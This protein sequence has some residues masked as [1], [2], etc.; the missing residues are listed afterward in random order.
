M[1]AVCLLRQQITHTIFQDQSSE[2]SQ[3]G[4]LNLNSS[5][6]VHFSEAKLFHFLNGICIVEL[7]E[8]RLYPIGQSNCVVEKASLCSRGL[9]SLWVCPSAA[10]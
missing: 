2:K 1:F 7:L 4:F 3:E 5:Q 6:I 10:L 8:K 9:R